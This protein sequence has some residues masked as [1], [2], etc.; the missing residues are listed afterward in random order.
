MPYMMLQYDAIV[1]LTGSKGSPAEQKFLN[2]TYI[3]SNVSVPP[4]L[5]TCNGVEKELTKLID[6]I[7]HLY[8]KANTQNAKVI[9]LAEQLALKVPVLIITG[10]PDDVSKIYKLFNSKNKA[11]NRVQTFVQYGEATEDKWDTIVKQSTEKLKNSV[12]YRITITDYWGGRGHDYVIN[13]DE[14]N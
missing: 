12:G 13:D 5:S 14:V 6:N 10:K 7:V 4:F 11:E 3:T 2:E 9:E 8:E 1:G